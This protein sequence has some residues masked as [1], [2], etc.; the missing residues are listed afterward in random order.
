MT[1]GGYLLLGFSY[2][3]GI[4]S[5]DEHLRVCCVSQVSL[6]LLLLQERYGQQLDMGLLWYLNDQAW[7]M[8]TGCL[9]ASRL[10]QGCIGVSGSLAN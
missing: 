1:R 3:L 10:R 2:C 8:T 7:H 6:Y 4:A 9:H 5:D